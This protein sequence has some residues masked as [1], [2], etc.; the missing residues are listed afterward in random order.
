MEGR[1]AGRRL[2]VKRLPT[3]APAN[4]AT[5][6]ARPSVPH[7]N[8]GEDFTGGVSAWNPVLAPW[9]SLAAKV[10]RAPAGGSTRSFIGA[11]IRSVV[12]P[13]DRFTLE[14]ATSRY[15]PR[16]SPGCPRRAGGG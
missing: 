15:E 12:P 1:G 13:A 4:S 7:E 3:N 2:E 8:P 6:M 11:V 9:S 14:G 16:T 5:A 10:R